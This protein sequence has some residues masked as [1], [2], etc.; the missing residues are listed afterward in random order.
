VNAAGQVVGTVFASITGGNVASGGDGLAVPNTIVRR[1][2][3][4]ARSRNR[5]VSTGQCAG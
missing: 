2:L 5:V 1:Q 3:N 4:V